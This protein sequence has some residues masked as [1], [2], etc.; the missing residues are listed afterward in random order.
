MHFNLSLIAMAAIVA[1]ALAAKTWDVNVVKGMFSPQELDIAPG[2]TVR[3][4]NND[5]A[6][7]AIVE[8][9][10]G[11]RTCNNKAGGFNSGRLTKGKAYQRTFRVAG[12]INYKDGIGAN[13][14]KGATGTIYVHTGPRPS[15]TMTRSPSGSQ[16]A[17][18][19]SSPTNAANSLSAEKS[20]LLGVACFI[21][22]LA[23]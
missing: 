12:T 3:W 15:G 18:P 5:G 2:D 4:P 8:T 1:P 10:A 9:N 16:T 19:I 17:A 11:A 14:V 6:D 23:L 22:A 21:G 7:H 20:V 13:C